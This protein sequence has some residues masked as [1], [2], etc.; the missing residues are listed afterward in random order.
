[1]RP[2][3]CLIAWSALSACVWGQTALPPMP[4]DAEAIAF[5]DPEPFVVTRQSVEA[6]G[7]SESPL[8]FEELELLSNRLATPMGYAPSVGYL[9][10]VGYR[11]TDHIGAAL[12]LDPY[13][14][15]P[16]LAAAVEEVHFG[17]DQSAQLLESAGSQLPGM[18]VWF[19]GLAC[20]WQTRLVN[21]RHGSSYL[22]GCMPEGY[23]L[24]SFIVSAPTT[25]LHDGPL[26]Q[27]LELEQGGSLKQ[28]QLVEGEQAKPITQVS[29][30][31]APPP[32]PVPGEDQPSKLAQLGQ[33][34]HVPGTSRNVNGH[35]KYWHA[36]LL[37]HQPLYFED[38]NLER[39]GFSNGVLQPVVS[40][41]K[42]F[43]TL[44]MLP[45]LM[46]A[47]P[48]HTTQYVLGE[49]RPGSSA[50]YV[51]QLPPVHADA[52]LAEAAA[53]TGLVFLIP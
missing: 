16:F 41:T 9:T 52:A 36:P 37:N 13:G 3:H 40:G 34:T 25:V 35:T 46:V 33:S 27:Q 11:G 32:G 31:I 51:Q 18:P 39:H 21:W 53:V 28:A 8:L 10:G 2:I 42:F 22:Q 20:E 45:Y 15:S 47:R 12:G 5:A 29:L 7:A 50:P 44:P 38:V 30:N 4:Q 17:L 14:R 23:A 26:E 19:D 1:M 43:T 48:P 49:S 24:Q 6:S